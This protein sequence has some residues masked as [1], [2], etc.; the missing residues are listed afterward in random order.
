MKPR[1]LQKTASSVVSYAPDYNQYFINGVLA[2]LGIILALM[3]AYL[4]CRAFFL[5]RTSS[6]KKKV[7][8][9]KQDLEVES[10]QEEERPDEEINTH[11]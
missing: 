6:K 5:L 9:V 11:R 4:A 10:P 3:C 2:A 8:A 1:N 7:Q